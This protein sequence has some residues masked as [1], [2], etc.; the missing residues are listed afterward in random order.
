MSILTKDKIFEE[1]KKGR[2]KII[3]FDPSQIGPGSIDLTLGNRFRIF[4]IAN[5]PIKIN[6]DT[7]SKDFTKEIT[8][9]QNNPLILKPRETVLGITEEKLTLTPNFCGWIEG[10]SRFARMGLA[11]HVSAGFIQP[12]TS[13]HQ[14]LEITN[15][16]PHT[17]ALIPGVK[18]CQIVIE[19]CEGKAIYR[20]HFKNQN[21][22]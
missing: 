20:G 2:I 9:S 14:V 17:L 3:P 4:K 13:N 18:I 8:I 16:S 6:E 10:R 22:P 1:I 7:D 21:R 19:H 15:L 11:V 5:Q 12:G